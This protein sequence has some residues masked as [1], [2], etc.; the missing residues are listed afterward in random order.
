MYGDILE[1]GD[2]LGGNGYLR[3]APWQR[4]R[5]GGK[6]HGSWLHAIPREVGLIS[7]DPNI[8]I[9]NV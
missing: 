3:S 1:G 9:P 8:S 6:S 5:E 7:Q 4:N 2:G